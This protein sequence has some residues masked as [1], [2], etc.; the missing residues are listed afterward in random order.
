[1]GGQQISFHVDDDACDEQVIGVILLNASSA[2]KPNG[3]RFRKGEGTH[4]L[5]YVLDERRGTAFM[6]EQ[7]AR[8]SWQHGLPPV[9]AR[10]ISV[11]VRFFKHRV[12]KES[13]V[14]LQKNTSEPP[15]SLQSLKS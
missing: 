10:R 4:T 2:G 3:L 9:P 12:L 1:M 13:L 8:Y 6:M 7:Q 5:E 15:S 11:T 14:P